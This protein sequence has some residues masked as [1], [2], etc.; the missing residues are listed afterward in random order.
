[1]KVFLL[2]NFS[3]ITI[4]NSPFGSIKYF[5][6]INID[7]I[8]SSNIFDISPTNKISLPKNIFNFWNNF[9]YFFG[10]IK[11]IIEQFK[12]DKIFKS[13]FKIFSFSGK[14]P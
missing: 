4:V 9:I 2:S 14:K 5:K 10:D 7:L 12:L 1:M 13:S 8:N 11:K 6:F 3:D